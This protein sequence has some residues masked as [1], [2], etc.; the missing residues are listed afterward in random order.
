MSVSLDCRDGLHR[1]CASCGGCCCE[2][3]DLAICEAPLTE[4]E[5]LELAKDWAQL[6]WEWPTPEPRARRTRA[7]GAAAQPR[8]LGR[9]MNGSPAVQLNLAAA[10]GVVVGLLIHARSCSCRPCARRDRMS[11]PTHAQVTAVGA[12]TALRDFA[13]RT[14][15]TLPAEA[16]A[17]RR[18]LGEVVLAAGALIELVATDESWAPASRHSRSPA[19]QLC[20]MPANGLPSDRPDAAGVLGTCRPAAVGLP[21]R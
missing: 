11:R 18:A 2:C 17:D 14:A 9:L 19:A 4:A 21:G 16:R 6:V 20:G 3:H 15:L 8:G 1:A 7:P 13:T 12:A 5:R 10:G